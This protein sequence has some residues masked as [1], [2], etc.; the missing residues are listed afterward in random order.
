MEPVIGIPQPVLYRWTDEE[1]GEVLSILV[2]GP[3]AFLAEL[4]ADGF[5]PAEMDTTFEGG[6]RCVV[7]ASA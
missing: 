1:T 5:L 2:Q 3:P 6:S 4:R 7:V